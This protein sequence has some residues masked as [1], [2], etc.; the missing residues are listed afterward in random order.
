MFCIANALKL[1]AHEWSVWGLGYCSHTKEPHVNPYGK[2][3]SESLPRNANL[4]FGL[5]RWLSRHK[6]WPC[7][8]TL[9][10]EPACKWKERNDSWEWSC[11]LTF[12]RAWHTYAATPLIIDVYF[13]IMHL[14]VSR[15]ELCK[16][17]PEVCRVVAKMSWCRLPG[18]GSAK[19]HCIG[20]SC[21]CQALSTRWS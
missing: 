9:I 11:S 21:L 7:N 19:T 18:L 16:R 5:V 6:Y 17:L 20:S 3:V 12:T 2:T 4:W 10:S 8:S 15:K 13:R 1:S 14:W